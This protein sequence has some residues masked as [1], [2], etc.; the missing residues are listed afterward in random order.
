MNGQQSVLVLSLQ[1]LC[2]TITHLKSSELL[3]LLPNIITIILPHFS[4]PLVDIRKNVIF[5]LVEIYLI[6]GDQLYPYVK[7]LAPSQRKLLTVYIERQI[8]RS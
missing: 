1:S 8:N 2:S 4:S 5:I 3:E 6:V 7:G